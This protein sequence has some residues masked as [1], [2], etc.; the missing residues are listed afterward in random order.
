MK[1]L[2]LLKFPRMQHLGF[3]KLF[4]NS[5][6][7]DSGRPRVH[8]RR[9]E[10]HLE[11]EPDLRRVRRRILRRRRQSDQR[12]TTKGLYKSQGNKHIPSSKCLIFCYKSEIFCRLFHFVIV[13]LP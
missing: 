6:E 2:F 4:Q 10:R 5:R 12:S 9:V 7:R 11:D 3:L 1:T 13:I 8:R